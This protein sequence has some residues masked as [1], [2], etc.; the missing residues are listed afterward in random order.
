MAE[1]Q[2]A[3]GEARRTLQ[4]LRDQR[5]KWLVL[6]GARRVRVVRPLEAQWGRFLGGV[7][8]EHAVE[9][10]DAWEGFTQADFVGADVGSSDAVEFDAELWGEY[11]RDHVKDVAQAVIE[12]IRD[13]IEERL[14]AREDARGN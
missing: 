1:K 12:A 14:K 2:D 6:E 3:A 7:G 8:V 11:C 5:R 13:A 9:Y 4:L 10:V